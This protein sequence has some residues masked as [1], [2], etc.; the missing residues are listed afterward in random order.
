MLFALLLLAAPAPR[1]F[2]LT[3]SGGV[4]LGAYEG[5]LTWAL[6]SYLR[7]GARDEVNLAGV[8]GASAGSI[9][10]LLAA[11]AFCQEGPDASLDD[12]PFRE[13]WLPVGLDQLLPE[14][15]SSFAGDDVLFRAAPLEET[16]ARLEQKLFGPG[17]RKFRP[18]CSVPIGISVTSTRPEGKPGA[19][20]GESGQ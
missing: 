15:N 5:G 4:S 11:A 14:D 19:G 16:L 12:N 7:S 10:A 13:V 9:N 3:I 18:G 6:V 17:A 8:T 1:Q 2:A 20:V